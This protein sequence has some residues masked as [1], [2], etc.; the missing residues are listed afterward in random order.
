MTRRINRDARYEN[1]RPGA[2]DRRID[3]AERSREQER[4][5]YIVLLLPLFLA[6]S[7]DD[8]DGDLYTYTSCGSVRDFRGRTCGREPDVVAN[9]EGIQLGEV[10]RVVR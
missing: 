5:F 6:C 9:Q 8:D 3:R 2:L 4:I 7:S 10:I 1:S